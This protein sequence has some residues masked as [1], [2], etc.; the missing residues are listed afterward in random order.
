MLVLMRNDLD[1]YKVITL[2]CILCVW[3]LHWLVSKRT[4]GL[5]GEEN[6]NLL[7]H[8]RLLALFII[9]IMFD[10]AAV[11]VFFK[12][13]IE[14]E[15]KMNDIYVIAGIEVGKPTTLTGNL[16]LTCPPESCRGQLQVPNSVVRALLQGAVARKKVRLQL[17]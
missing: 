11:V 1:V 16:V 8:F 2:I 17:Y 9:L 4:K 12:K 14:L 7:T 10:L 3:M 13:Y 6:R 15:T 5:I